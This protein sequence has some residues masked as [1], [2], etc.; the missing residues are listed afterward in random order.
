VPP[1]LLC[2]ATAVLLAA[3]AAGYI[4]IFHAENDWTGISAVPFAGQA[5]TTNRPPPQLRA[6]SGGGQEYQSPRRSKHIAYDHTDD[7]PQ[8]R[9]PDGEGHASARNLPLVW[10]ERD[11]VAWKTSVPG[12]GWSSPI[13]FGDRVWLT[14]ADSSRPPLRLIGIE[15]AT[16]RI[17]CNWGVIM[18]EAPI[19]VHPK[20]S[21]ATPTPVINDDRLYA[22]FGPYG[23]AC[24]TLDGKIVWTAA[25]DYITEYGPTS[26]P[27]V[28]R[29]LLILS[30]HGSDLQYIVARDKSSG[31]EIWKQQFPGR[32]SES[33][34]LVVFRAEG[35][36]LICNLAGQLIALDPATGAQHWSLETGTGYAQVARPVFGHDCVFACGGYFDPFVMA[37]R[38]SSGSAKAHELWKTRNASAPYIVSPLLV[39]D[40]LY[41]IGPYGFLTCVDAT[42][43]R[44]CYRERLAAEVSAS[45]VF[46]DGRIYIVDEEGTTT[47]IRLGRVFRKLAVNRLHERVQASPAIAGNEIFLRTEK[48]LYCIVNLSLERDL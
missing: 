12:L 43:G 23:T 22:N 8:F 26:S 47:V 25:E 10:T 40:E 34:P 36:L 45:P 20:N 18:P 44:E 35:D 30:C 17:V 41:L 14:T 4:S 42:T 27:L 15:R 13:I 31:K 29:N 16:G 7:W 37:V 24:L 11:N 5:T 46:A 2:V 9:G 19:K 21:H 33:T 28:W 39:G 32:N 48:A 6:P 3:V 38:L 1:R